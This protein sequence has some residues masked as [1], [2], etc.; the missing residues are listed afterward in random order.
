MPS[1]RRSLTG[2]GLTNGTVA[3]VL[4]LPNHEVASAL[5]EAGSRGAL[6]RGLG[7]SYGDAAQNAGGLVLRLLGA[8]HQAV[9]DPQRATATVPAGVSMDDLLRVIV[10]R[11]FF[12]PVTPGTRFVTIG[13]AIASDIHGKNHHGEG[14]FGNHVESLTM[15]LADGSQVVVGPQ[16]RPELFWATVGGMGLT[17]VI[18]DATISLIPIETSR[19]SVDTTRIADLDTL[20]ATMTE[21]DDDYRYS[22]AWIDP[23]A[24]GRSLG[25]SV[26]G[27]G[28]HARLDQLGPKEAIEPL[29]YDAK[30]LVTVPP[31]VPRMGF[32]NHAT[33]AAFNEMWYRKAPRHRVGELQGIATFF[34]PLDMVSRWNRIY[35]AHGML[36]YQVVVP[37]GAEE[38][39]RTVIE[40]FAAS[41]TASFLAV[42]KRFGPGSL[43]PMS[44]PA[45]GWTL[46]LDVPAATGGLGDLLHS[47][48]RLVLDAGGRHY[49]A[50]DSVTTPEA[51]R[52]GYPRLAEWKA[53]RDAVDP[54][55]LWQ[56]DLSRRLGLTD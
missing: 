5:K 55:G 27:R 15:L 42:L 37:F 17:G 30:Q 7:R 8:A 9:L 18:L 44:F 52:R 32:I 11:G 20:L 38:T 39:M 19:M 12:V 23:Q 22:V 50:K 24:K 46:T 34:H 14:S 3:D 51:I 53:I 49:F 31:L 10:P 28:D 33:V 21:G 41:G 25:R 40:R 56:S 26:L 36:Q 47:L 2:W 6:V 43:A 13:G 29:A 1:R 54:T 35:G 4:E 48:D 45:P 16:Q